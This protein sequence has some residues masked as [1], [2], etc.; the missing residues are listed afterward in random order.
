MG[1]LSWAQGH[2]DLIG[3]YFGAILVMA[4]QY[5]ESIE[6]TTRVLSGLFG[7]VLT[8]VLIYKAVL[9]IRKSKKG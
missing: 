9:D 5:I 4:P 7:L 8:G 6:A 1:I 2:K 3:R